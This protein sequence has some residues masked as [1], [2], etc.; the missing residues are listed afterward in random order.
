MEPSAFLAIAAPNHPAHL[1]AKLLKGIVNLLKVLPCRQ[2]VVS[3]AQLVC[4]LEAFFH[5]HLPGSQQVSF[6]GHDQQ[7][8]VGIGVDL[9]DM[10]VQGADGAVAVMV[11]DGIDKHKTI[12]PVDGPV[13]LFL[14]A[15]S[16]TL[17]L[18]TKPRRKKMIL[19][20]KEQWCQGESKA[21]TKPASPITFHVREEK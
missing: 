12:C 3:A 18:S 14:A 21:Q 17:V 7:R 1:L 8:Y 10:L 6:I 9:P 19:V 11:R 15:D 2:L 16:V 20:G 13:Y 5:R 4:Q